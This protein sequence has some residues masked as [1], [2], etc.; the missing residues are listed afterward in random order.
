MDLKSG[1]IYWPI[2]DGEIATYAPLERDAK[3]EV[4]VI[5]WYQA[6]DNFQQRGFSA[7]RRTEQH[8]D[9]AAAYR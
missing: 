2:A 4:A 7:S 9:F 5:G 3:C 8:N 1:R 6:R